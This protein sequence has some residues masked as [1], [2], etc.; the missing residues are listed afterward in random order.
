MAEPV[1]WNERYD[2]F[3]AKYPPGTEENEFFKDVIETLSMLV[4]IAVT[5]TDAEYNP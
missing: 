5:N 2:K 1:N 4:R 3:L